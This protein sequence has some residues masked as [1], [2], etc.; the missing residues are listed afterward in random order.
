MGEG[1]CN[2]EGELHGE[3]SYAMYSPERSRL[4]LV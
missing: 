4:K 2:G 3:G 1:R